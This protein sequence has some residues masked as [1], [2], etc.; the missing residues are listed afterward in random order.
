ERLAVARSI[1]EA[2]PHLSHSNHLAMFALVD[3][4]L[5]ALMTDGDGAVHEMAVGL[6]QN[7]GMKLLY[8]G[9]YP[10]AKKLLDIVVA[11]HVALPETLRA[12]WECRLYLDACAGAAL[13]A[14]EEDW[15]RAA[16]LDAPTDE[17]S[18]GRCMFWSGDVTDRRRVALARVANALV[19]RAN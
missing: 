15:E 9:A 5:P 1:A 12:R 7:L 13:D 10:E 6:A 8:K 18:V 2:L 19:A 14:A 17:S 4:V 11:H 3:G 16:E